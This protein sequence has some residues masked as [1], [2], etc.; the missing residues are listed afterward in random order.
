M[1]T[2]AEGVRRGERRRGT[3]TGRGTYGGDMKRRGT[4]ADTGAATGDGGVEAATGDGGGLEGQRRG[5]RRGV[6]RRG[7]GGG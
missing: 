2:G 3:A 5:R 1:R 6:G 7:F 4:P